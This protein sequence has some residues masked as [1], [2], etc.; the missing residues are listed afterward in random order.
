MFFPD[1]APGNEGRERV[2]SLSGE[3][4]ETSSACSALSH[5]LFL[6]HWVTFLA[7][8]WLFVAVILIEETFNLVRCVTTHMS[9]FPSNH[10]GTAR[11]A[12]FLWGLIYINFTVTQ[13]NHLALA[14]TARYH[15]CLAPNPSRMD[16]I[17]IKILD[18]VASI[19]WQVYIPSFCLGMSPAGSPSHT[20][21]RTQP[22]TQIHGHHSFCFNPAS[23]AKC[24]FH[25]QL[26][27]ET[28]PKVK[29]P[30]D[31]APQ[32]INETSNGPKNLF[33]I[34]YICKHP[35]A[36]KAAVMQAYNTLIL[37]H[38][39]VYVSLGTTNNA[40]KCHPSTAGT[41]TLD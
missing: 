19:V 16:A 15:H 31:Q 37:E 5:S 38:K 8:K 17:N 3:D 25:H 23:C 33:A 6:S 22:F 7:L 10:H 29:K 4:S 32:R 24:I 26:I 11:C 9:P 14:Q 21:T 13:T 1:G 36:S 39:Q 30:D 40:N 28:K 20:N 35:G 18:S 2:S 41:P 12:C 34:D 27:P